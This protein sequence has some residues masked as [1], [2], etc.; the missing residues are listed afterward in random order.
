MANA[1][2]GCSLDQHFS[3]QYLPARR[4]LCGT[5]SFFVLVLLDASAVVAVV[6]GTPGSFRG[7]SAFLRV[8]AFLFLLSLLGLS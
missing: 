8:S 4:T 7:T 5:T 2:D 1:S 3:C 6:V